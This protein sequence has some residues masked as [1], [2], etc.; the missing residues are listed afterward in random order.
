GTKPRSSAAVSSARIHM[1]RIIGAPCRARDDPA[2]RRIGSGNDTM[3]RE[4]QRTEA[5]L[6]SAAVLAPTERVAFIKR[7]CGSDTAMLQDVETHL[8]RSPPARAAAADSG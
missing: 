3:A 8:P 5:L 2:Y 6:A 4:R 7:E 1:N